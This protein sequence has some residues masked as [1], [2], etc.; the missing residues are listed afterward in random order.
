MACKLSNTEFDLKVIFDIG[1]NNGEYAKRFTILQDADIYCFEPH[2]HTYQR[3]NEFASLH[4]NVETYNIGLS[5]TEG[6]S[7]LYDHA[8]RKGTTNATLYKKVITDIR[9]TDV[10]EFE[11]QLTTLDNFVKENEVKRIDLLKLDVEGNEMK[12]LNGAKKA[13]LN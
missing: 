1:A 3:L 9:R 7:T 12:V 4:S 2:P 8:K 6:K 11:I 13:Y 5:D 10:E